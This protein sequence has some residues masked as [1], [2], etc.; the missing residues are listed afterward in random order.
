MIDFS[1]GKGNRFK[2]LAIINLKYFN[3]TDYVID[4]LLFIQLTIEAYLNMHNRAGFFT[5]IP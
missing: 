5:F 3:I 1:G 2:Q 4:I